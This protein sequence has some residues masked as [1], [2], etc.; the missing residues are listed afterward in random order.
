MT[1]TT[2][3]TLAP[4]FRVLADEMRRMRFGQIENLRIC[5]GLPVFNPAPVVVRDIRL[6]GKAEGKA[7]TEQREFVLSDALLEMIRAFG[8]VGDGVALRIDV[9]HGLPQRMKVSESV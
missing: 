2:S 4:A 3:K 6:D 5:G 9:M 8:E 1:T 7:N